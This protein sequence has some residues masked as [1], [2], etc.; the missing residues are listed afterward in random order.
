MSNH[1]KYLDALQ[2][3]QQEYIEKKQLLRNPKPLS[4]KAGPLSTPL[5]HLP[6]LQ[7]CSSLLLSSS[8]VLW[9]SQ[10]ELLLPPLRLPLPTTHPLS[11]TTTTMGTTHRDMLSQ[12]MCSLGTTTN[13][14]G[15]NHTMDTMGTTTT[16][17][18]Y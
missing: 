6:P 4:Y 16:T 5:I 12:D 14:M 13:T 3:Y 9:L 11:T 8:P 10:L 2:D 15:T 7:P 18:L 17:T 1:Y